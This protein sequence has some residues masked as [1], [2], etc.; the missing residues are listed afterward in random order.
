M[1]NI[2]WCLCLCA[3]LACAMS[4]VRA[5]GYP[6][7]PIR[8]IVPYVPGGGAD[9]MARLIAPRLAERL[10]QQVVIDNRGGGGSNIG[11]EL[12]AKNAPDGYTLLMGTAA[13]AI[14]VSLYSK[15]AFDPL[16][17]FTAVTLLA[18]TPNVIAVHPS[19][20]VKSV[21]ELIALAKAAPGQINYG[22]G[23]SGTTPHLT[24]ELFKVMAKVNLVHIPYRSVG[25]AVIALL[26]GEVS[27]VATSP[28]VLMPHARTGRLR[29]LGITSLDRSPAL[30]E[31]PTV[32]ESGLPG[33][34]VAQWYG[35]LVPVGAPDAVVFSLNV[36]LVKIMQTPEVNEW[37]VREASLPV[38][39]TA[40][41]FAAY[42]REEVAK[43]S[44]VVKYSGARVD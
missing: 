38:G 23:G 29:V 24:M 33:Y 35:V 10:G 32:A 18:K 1:K 44:K 19:L 12:A 14:N 21:R 8:F 30:P 6:V 25:P 3:A 37:L 7:K 15:L 2:M 34:E 16:K 13:T 26:S 31:L 4:A 22:S 27:V 39:S 20:P 9:A 11:T 36:E 43:W 40:Q 42:L 17:D 41:E 5:Q 28:L